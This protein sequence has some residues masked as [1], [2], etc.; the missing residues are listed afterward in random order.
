[1]PCAAEDLLYRRDRFIKSVKFVLLKE[2]QSLSNHFFHIIHPAGVKDIFHG[3]KHLPINFEMVVCSFRRQCLCGILPLL[4][5][6]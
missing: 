2:K 4:Q 1:M 5:T 6:R 3:Q